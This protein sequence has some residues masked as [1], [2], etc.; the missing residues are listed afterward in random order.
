MTT[1]RQFTIDGENQGTGSAIF[2]REMQDAFAVGLSVQGNQEHPFSTQVKGYSGERLRFAALRFSPHTT[3]S[4]RATGLRS[5]LLVSLHREGVALVHQEGRETRIEPDDLFIIDPSRPFF[6]EAG[7]VLA[8]SLY[9]EHSALRA[10]MPEIELH[11]AR[12][13]RTTYGAGAVLRHTIDQLLAQTDRLSDLEADRLADALPFLIAA[14]LA[15]TSPDTRPPPSRLRALHKQRIMGY[16]KDNLRNHEIDAAHIAAAISLST[17]YIYELFEDEDVPLM[18]WIWQTRLER[19]RADLASAAMR[20]R[21]IGEIAFYWGFND[22]TH[23]SRAFRQR[24][25]VSPRAFRKT[26]LPQDAAH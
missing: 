6:I 25:G 11:T 20:S 22:I 24:Y 23:F 14:S 4:P 13:V 10:I 15:G 8:H 3:C 2:R 1:I 17:R 12:Q 26:A 5:R 19:C 7:N 21:S 9:I 16:V 18:K